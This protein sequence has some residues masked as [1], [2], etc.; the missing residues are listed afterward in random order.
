MVLNINFVIPVLRL[1]QGGNRKERGA[2]RL[3][4]QTL[5]KPDP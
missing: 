2:L 3:S 5:N 1:S 4:K